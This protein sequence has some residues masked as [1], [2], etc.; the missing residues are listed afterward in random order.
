MHVDESLLA[1]V[2]DTRRFN[3][4][5]MAAMA[6]SP[7]GFATAEDALR[8]RAV[9]DAAIAPLPPD[10]LQPQVLTV[11]ATEPAVEVRVFVPDR[12]RG[13][14]VQF[15]A[16]AWIIGS[17]R[18]SDDR[19]AE[20]AERCSVAVVSVEYRMVPEALPPA[21]LEDA[22]NVIDWVRTEG[23]ALVGD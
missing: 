8:T 17:A 22:L 11:G 2:E 13:V 23:Q 7:L 19:S 9:L 18:A 15:H 20:I 4:Q 12:P 5:Y 10:R 21:Q 16:G 14:C 6:S 3:E 1:H